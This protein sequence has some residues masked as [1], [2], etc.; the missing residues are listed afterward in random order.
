MGAGLDSTS[1]EQFD[2]LQNSYI[3]YS[4]GLNKFIGKEQMIILILN[5]NPK[6][7]MVEWKMSSLQARLYSS[8]PL[9][10]GDIVED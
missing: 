7:F 2:F 1:I 3:V 5:V 4:K 6:Y 9:G 8:S 10:L